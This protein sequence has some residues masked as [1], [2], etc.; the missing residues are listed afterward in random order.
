MELVEFEVRR[1]NPKLKVQ[2]SRGNYLR[3]LNVRG[4]MFVDDDARGVSVRNLDDVVLACA[5]FHQQP[6]RETPA[7]PRKDSVVGS[8]GHR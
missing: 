6:G 4:E 3:E 8:A 7:S 2:T 5:L 1:K